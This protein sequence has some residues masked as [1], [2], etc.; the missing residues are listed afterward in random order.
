MFNEKYPNRLAAKQYFGVLD[1]EVWNLKKAYRETCLC[2]TCFN[3]R[4]FREGLAVVAKLIEIL[5]LPSA[6]QDAEVGQQDEATSAVVEDLAALRELHT[7]CASCATGKRRA[8][9]KLVC[10]HNFHDARQ[11]CLS[12]KCTSCGFKALWMP[13]RKT[14]VFDVPAGKLRP[15]VSEVWT[16][17]MIWDSIKT[18]GDGSNSEDDLRQQHSGTVIAFLDKAMQAYSNFVPH[19]FHMQQSKTS[20]REC[21]ENMVPGMIRDNTDWSENGECKVKHQMQ[22]EY[23]SIVNYSLLITISSFL[24]SSIWK[25][26]TSPL[27]YCVIY[28]HSKVFMVQATRLCNLICGLGNTCGLFRGT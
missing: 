5:L 2:R 21:Y 16:T 1:K 11:K 6:S 3:N 27:I 20:D 23:W 24:I 28:C 4:L 10:A 18:G 8:N 12:G 7:F 14:L 25:D 19:S 26:R 13:V 22:S 15:G 17:E 9:E